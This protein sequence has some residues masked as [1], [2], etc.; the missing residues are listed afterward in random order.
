MRKL[1]AALIATF[2][3]VVLAPAGALAK[4]FT[5]EVGPPGKLPA[6]LDLSAFFPS[7]L[8]VHVGD[9]V[10]FQINEFHTISYLPP[11]MT[12][13]PLAIPEPGSRAED[14]RDAA[15]TPFW[16]DSA[17]QLEVN[18]LVALPA[19]GGTLNPNAYVNSGLPNRSRPTGVYLLRF[20]QAGTFRLYCL[21]HRGMSMVVHVVRQ[22]RRI[23]S[24]AQ[25][26][27]T[28]RAQLHAAFAL[29]RR[30]ER[31]RPPRLTVLAGHDA[32]PVSWM[33]FFPERLR[34]RVGQTVTF[35]VDS[36]MDPHTITFG[37][38]SYTSAIEQTLIEPQTTPGGP[39]APVF[40][41]LGVYPS[42][43][44]GT[45]LIY[46]GSNHGNGFLNSGMLDTDPHT[47]NPSEVRI[48]FTRTGTYHF[49]CVIHPDMDG[50][51]TVTPGQPSIS[52]RS[53]P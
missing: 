38:A 32:G 29:A 1:T 44:P 34:I 28:A 43:P 11:G 47:P 41:P 51:I 16:F 45:P 19:G 26:R 14:L 39:P 18:P 49:E 31:L 17:P 4:T 50:T 52:N 27:A 5:V 15:G 37:P 9:S 22:G 8:T 7:R 6:H 24:T 12:P 40:N 42:D 35:R 20:T 36:M 53:R 13:P 30:L 33:R 46:T 21:V 10:R 2:V 25:V 48:T 3:M 23:P